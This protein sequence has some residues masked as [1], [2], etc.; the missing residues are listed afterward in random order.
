M[1]RFLPATADLPVCA[2]DQHAHHPRF[3]SPYAALRYP[4][5]FL[6]LFFAD[7]DGCNCACLYCLFHH[8]PPICTHLF[9][10]CDF[11]L[12]YQSNASVVLQESHA[13][14]AHGSAHDFPPAGSPAR[15]YLTI[16]QAG[17]RNAR[18]LSWDPVAGR[19]EF[20]MHGA[21]ETDIFPEAR[22][23][24]IRPGHCPFASVQAVTQDTASQRIQYILICYPFM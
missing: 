15:L 18:L 4:T 7:T 23:R 21:D 10:F 5:F 6:R 3:P 13:A 19:T 11:F 2:S 9:I 20:P 1:H 17:A 24:S 16:A 14:V 12:L 8:Y 22:T